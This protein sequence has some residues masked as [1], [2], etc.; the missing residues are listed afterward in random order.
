MEKHTKNILT[1]EFIFK[2]L[3]FYNT[4]DIRYNTVLTISLSILLLPFSV[5][6]YHGFNELCE[7]N[8]LSIVMSLFMCSPV[9]YLIYEF[10]PLLRQRKKIKNGEFEIVKRKVLHKR[11]KAV[12]FKHS[13]RLDRIIRFEG[14]KE[15][16]VGGSIYEMTDSGEEFYIVRYQNEKKV[17]LFYSAKR[18]EYNEA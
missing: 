11:E 17:R 14:F 16:T 8:I 4:A 10:Y 15:L 3:S 2:E 13:M 1:R 7:N 9:L 5:L 18:Y 6:I 12:I